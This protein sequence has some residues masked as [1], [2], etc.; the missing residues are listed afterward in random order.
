MV[1][2]P[3]FKCYLKKGKYSLKLFLQILSKHSFHFL[4]NMLKFFTEEIIIL[5]KRKEVEF[6]NKEREAGS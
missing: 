3:L 6:Y 2:P 4:Q 1:C 5:V